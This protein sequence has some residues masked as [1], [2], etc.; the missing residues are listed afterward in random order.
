ML[1]TRYFFFDEFKRFLP[2]FRQYRH[3][4]VSFK[5]GE[6]L[7]KPSDLFKYNFYITE[8]LCKVSVL[9]ASGDEKIIAYWGKGSIY[10]IICSE[11]SFILENSI[12]VTA[13]TDVE[14]MRY[15]TE[16]TKAMMREH[17]EISYE[18][19]DHYCKF[20][21]LLFFCTATQTYEDV[22]TRICNMLFIY[23]CNFNENCFAL[24]QGELASMIG[25]KR[26]SVVK[27]IRE[28]RDNGIISTTRHHIQILSL[29]KLEEYRSS[30]LR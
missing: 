9:H 6:L 12:V 21:N 26:E 29:E 30:L 16:T 1:Q 5:K 14:T 28:L 22:K 15:D 19:I 20:T 2:I 23:Y 27:I 17:P 7:K 13:M 10:P 4:I 11:Q 25:A 3:E 18:M 8:G 24:T